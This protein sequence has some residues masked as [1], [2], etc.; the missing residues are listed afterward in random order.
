MACL[1]GINVC[2]N[3]IV[4]HHIIWNM[5]CD[6]IP[7][8]LWNEIV[9]SQVQIH[10]GI[11]AS[12]VPVCCSMFTRWIFQVVAYSLPRSPQCDSCHVWPASH[13]TCLHYGVSPLLIH[14]LHCMAI[15]HI[16]SG[17]IRDTI[18]VLMFFIRQSVV[19]EA[20][21][22]CTTMKTLTLLTHWGRGNIAAILQTIFSNAFS[23]MKMY[24]F[25][26]RFQWY[27]FLGFELTIFQPWFR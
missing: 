18:G 22:W 1:L 11:F 4:G 20:D 8:C 24:E 26:L 15:I 10:Y 16:G 2:R 6:N 19:W 21:C 12:S 7:C 27:L 13:A 23:W 3:K 25:R 9:F 17:L 14:C 5:L